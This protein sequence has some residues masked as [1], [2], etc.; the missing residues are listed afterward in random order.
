MLCSAL[1]LWRGA[2]LS[3]FTNSVQRCGS[4]EVGR[5]ADNSMRKKVVPRPVVCF[6]LMGGGDVGVATL[7]R[8]VISALLP[9]LAVTA[10]LAFPIG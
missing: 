5:S 8:I 10:V 1:N 9:S 4:C 6:V 7:G 2:V 3:V